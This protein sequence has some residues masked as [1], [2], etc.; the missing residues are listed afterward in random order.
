MRQVVLPKYMADGGDD[1]A[2]VKQGLLQAHGT[3]CTPRICSLT[4]NVPM[5]CGRVA[6]APHGSKAATE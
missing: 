1:Y 3:R 5:P 2:M 6:K 4:P